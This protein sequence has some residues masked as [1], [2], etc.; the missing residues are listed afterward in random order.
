MDKFWRA[1]HEMG[2]CHQSTMLSKRQPSIN[3]SMMAI[4]RPRLTRRWFYS[5]AYLQIELQD[6]LLASGITEA[7][8]ACPRI[9][10]S[11]HHLCWCFRESF[12]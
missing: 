7:P 2:I 4:E 3:R 8:G 11:P 6:A 10:Y 9:P 1:V 5:S 12:A